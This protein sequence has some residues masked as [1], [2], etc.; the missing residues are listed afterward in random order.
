MRL[1][2]HTRM[3][4]QGKFFNWCYREQ[5]GRLAV[6]HVE[7][8][9][10]H[11]AELSASYFRIKGNKNSEVTQGQSHLKFEQY[12]VKSSI[13][14]PPAHFVSQPLYLRKEREVNETALFYLA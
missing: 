12:F 3:R 6:T 10:L 5:F 4:Y 9:D 7:E 14:S 13:D 2:C 8:S 11:P 1:D